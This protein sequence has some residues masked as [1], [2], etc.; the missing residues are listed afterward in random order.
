MPNISCIQPLSV[1]IPIY[2]FDV[3]DTVYTLIQQLKGLNVD[4][5]IILKDDFS[6]ARFRSIN[7]PLA[8]LPEVNYTELSENI[9]R[10][11]IRN[12]LAAKAKY[13][14]ILFLDCDVIIHRTNFI[15]NYIKAIA[16]GYEVICGGR[17]YPDT[18]TNKAQ[19]L[20][21]NY[22][23]KY[24]S[25]SA[26]YRSMNPSRSF[27]T[28][29]FAIKR[30]IFSYITFNESL[31]KYGHEDTLFGYDLYKAGIIPCHI[32]NPVLNGDIETTD[33][34]LEKTRKGIENLALLYH[35]NINNKEFAESITLTAVYLKINNKTLVK[36][37]LKLLA[38]VLNPLF[39]RGVSNALLFNIY[40]LGY[41]VKKV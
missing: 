22:G 9:G 5:E 16:A 15:D 27:M 4:F 12:R 10:S 34:F 30:E 37:A 6:D 26:E 19:M 41:F 18:C 3:R 39:A 23:R 32:N 2:N 40:K 35:N 33:V 17:E 13:N 20:R 38:K 29:N 14:Y 28:N 25:R 1:C 36:Y 31:L 11:K 21:W 7:S 24:E 8:T